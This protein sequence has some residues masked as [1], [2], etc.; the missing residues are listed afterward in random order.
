M[1]VGASLL[2][3]AAVA[4]VLTITPGLDMALVI[5]YATVFG[6]GPALAAGAGVCGGVLIWGIAAAV[7]VSAVLSVSVL[8]FTVMKYLGAAYMVWLAF[9]MLRHALG[10]GEPGQSDAVPAPERATTFGAFRK[11]LLVNVLNPKVGAFYVALLPQF[12]PVGVNGVVMGAA[13]ASVHVAETLLWFGLIV[14]LI[15]Q[16][17]VFL[18]RQSVQRAID[19][20]VGVALLGFAA[21][22]VLD[23]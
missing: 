4:L 8:A 5:R 13:L 2:G 22:L 17:R 14:L 3:F 20:F 7:G 11:G 23:R 16:I 21:K 1:T 6:R 15:G 18:Q 9:G 19:G 12:L 10:R